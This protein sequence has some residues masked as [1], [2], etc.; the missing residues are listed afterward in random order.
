MPPGPP[1][2]GGSVVAGCQCRARRCT[3]KYTPFPAYGQAGARFFCHCDLKSVT[4][5]HETSTTRQAD[6]I[7]SPAFDSVKHHR[8]AARAGR[9]GHHGPR[10]QCR[11]YRRHCRGVYDFQPCLLDI[12]ILAHGHQRHDVAGPGPSRPAGGD[13]P[14]G[15]LARGS[16][17]CGPCAAA[18]ARPFAYGYA[19]PDKAHARRGPSGGPLFPYMRVGRPRHARPLR[20]HR[21]V[22]R[23][24][25]HPR[26]HVHIHHAERG[27]HSCEPHTRGLGRPEA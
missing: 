11:L 3:C 19:R 25:E 26:A 4:L 24:A 17:W 5:H 15:A 16:L 18:L 2:V 1:C 12:R 23:H 10:G 9:C 14:A 27:K 7:D 20:A 22:H 6:T 8:A 21:V 13:A